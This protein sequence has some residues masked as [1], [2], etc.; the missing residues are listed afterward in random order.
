MEKVNLDY[1]EKYADE[2]FDFYYEIKDII[3][4]YNNIFFE[5]NIELLENNKLIK[6]TNEVLEILDYRLNKLFDLETLKKLGLELKNNKFISLSI[7]F[8]ELLNKDIFENMYHNSDIINNKDMI[9]GK[10]ENMNFYNKKKC[11]ETDMLCNVFQNVIDDKLQNI[12]EFGCGKLY[13]TYRF[14]KLF[15]NLK[16]YGYDKNDDLMNKINII[17]SIHLENKSSKNENGNINEIIY[18]NSNDYKIKGFQNFKN[19]VENENENQNKIIELGGKD[20]KK[21]NKKVKLD[22]KSK[23]KE[24]NLNSRK[25]KKI[26]IIDKEDECIKELIE[27]IN[28]ESLFIT[29]DSFNNMSKMT[30]FNYRNSILFGL[31][32][33]GN[34]TSTA[35]RVFKDNNLNFRKLCII[36]CCLNLLTEKI[37]DIDYVNDKHV[38]KY[39]EEIDFDSKG[40]YL[41]CTS[42]INNKSLNDNEYGYPLSKYF[43]NYPKSIFLSRIARLSAMKS[44]VEGIS[45]ENNVLNIETSIFYREKLFK[46]IFESFINKIKEFDICKRFRAL[47]Y[48]FGDK[49]SINT[50]FLEYLKSIFYNIANLKDKSKF[51]IVEEKFKDFKFENFTKEI[52]N[53]NKELEDYNSYFYI[54]A[55]EFYQKMKNYK[56]HLFS[57]YIIKIKFS[58]IIEY[59]ILIDRILYLRENLSLKTRVIKI[60]EDKISMRNLLIYSE[61]M[62]L[63]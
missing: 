50:S 9:I 18:E 56:N 38:K 12:V 45:I 43:F 33:C 36:G 27:R 24:N 20:N 54:Y 1:Y 41:D 6:D 53:L 4:I 34:L 51:L 23:L 46:T 7:K 49:I 58:K 28:I 55:D 10:T 52:F 47:I 32:S 31:H 57:A 26:K 44:I 29:F 14:L 60:F 48:H 15:P 42:H 39:F 16:Y 61:R 13:Q 59:I 17:K 8:Q 22:L 37:R 62:D 19:E 3:L 2:L 35:L 40:N 63:L 25:A 11:Y 30:N 21:S 5:D